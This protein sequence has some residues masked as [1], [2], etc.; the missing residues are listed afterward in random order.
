M[1]VLQLPVENV[2][3]TSGEKGD[4]NYEEL[5]STIQR[6]SYKRCPPC[7]EGP[8]LTHVV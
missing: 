7:R 1:T 2:G 8:F 3:G 4:L 5:P 6:C